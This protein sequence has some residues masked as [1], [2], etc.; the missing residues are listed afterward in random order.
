VAVGDSLA[1]VGHTA[2]AIIQYEK[3][4]QLDARVDVARPLARLYAAVGD[5]G[6]ARDE[7]RKALEASPRDANLWNDFG[8]FQY[9]LGDWKGA[10]TALHKAVEMDPHLARAWINLGLTLGQQQQYQESLAAFEK[11]VS[12]A[13]ARCNLGFVLTTQGKLD[14]AGEAYRSALAIDPQQSK[15]RLGLAQ[16]DRMKAGGP[17]ANLPPGVEAKPGTGANGGS[18]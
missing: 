16:L 2:E 6:R 11:A 7:Y 10:D 18:N 17:H 5:E 9:N 8:Y 4:R 12:P 3:A 13:E 1:G 14:E 15:A